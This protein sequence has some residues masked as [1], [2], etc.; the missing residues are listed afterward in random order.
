MKQN[1]MNS[2]LVLREITNSGLMLAGFCSQYPQNVHRGGDGAHT[3][4]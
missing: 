3:V 4:R 2:S 1:L